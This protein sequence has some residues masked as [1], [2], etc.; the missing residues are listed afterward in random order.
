MIARDILQAIGGL[1]E[2]KEKEVN[3]DGV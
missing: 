1:F 2:E 3:H